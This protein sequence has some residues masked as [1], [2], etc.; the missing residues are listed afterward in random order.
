MNW[1][2][3][4]LKQYAVFRGRSRRKEYWS[5]LLFN[6]F[7]SLLAIILDNI[8]G[9]AIKGFGFGPI[10]GLYSLAIIIPGLAVAVRRLHDVGKSGLMIFISLIPVIGAIWLLVL[11]F[12]DSNSGENEY[13]ANPK[14]AQADDL[15]EDKS[16]GDLIILVVVIWIFFSRAFWT[17]MPVIID[18]FYTTSTMEVTSKFISLIWAI[19]PISLAFAIKNKS[20]QIIVFIFGGVYLLNTYY[21]MMIQF[22]K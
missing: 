20:K 14:D 7:L 4:V 16:T 22:L 3:K 18:D 11:M 21:E 19:I 8:I 12:T 6:I 13:G 17:F 2:L 1:Y 5:F 15:L 9:I 10:Y